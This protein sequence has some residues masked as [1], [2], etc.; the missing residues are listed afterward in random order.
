MVE[1]TDGFELAERDLEIRGE[2]QLLGARQSG[3][4][5]LRFVRLRQD[6]DLLERARDR[7]RGARRRGAARG[8]RRPPPRR[9]RAPRRVVRIVAGSRKGHRIAAPK[10]VV[11]R[12]TSDRVREAVFSIVGPV[13]GAAAL[14][15]FAG[16]GALGLEAP[17]ARRCE[18]CL[19]RARPRGGAR[20]RGEPREA[21]ARRGDRR[22]SRRCGGAPRRAGAQPALRPRARRS[23]VRGV[24]GARE[25]ARRPAPRP[26]R[27]RR[28]RGR[29]DLAIASSRRF[30]STSSRP[31]G[32]VPRA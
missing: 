18:L 16:S 17:V 22:E 9:G 30:R 27:G 19:R 10:G 32:T 3:L 25:D 26:A 28:A 23:A 20:D 11:T 14:D 5:D 7:A 8:R 12:P 13:E 31:G 6:R 15:L 21:P 29:R 2:G 1:T 24:G 4:S